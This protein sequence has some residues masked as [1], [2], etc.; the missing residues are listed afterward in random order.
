MRSGKSGRS[1]VKCEPLDASDAFVDD[2]E[3]EISSDEE[4][5]GSTD[6]IR[7]SHKMVG[8]IRW[9]CGHLAAVSEIMSG[10]GLSYSLI[11]RV[12]KHAKRKK[13]QVALLQRVGTTGRDALLE[14]SISQPQTR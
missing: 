6:D 14:S 5:W 8:F 10:T 7:A 1:E 2:S 13:R 11:C 12:I 3:I 4:S 9:D